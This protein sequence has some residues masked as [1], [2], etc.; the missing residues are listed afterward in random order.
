MTSCSLDKILGKQYSPP[1]EE[2]SE[3]ISQA[4]VHVVLKSRG[5]VGASKLKALNISR[6]I[7]GCAIFPTPENDADPLVSQG[8]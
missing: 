2:T 7:V 1:R 3:V 5:Q 4:S 8:S 6:F